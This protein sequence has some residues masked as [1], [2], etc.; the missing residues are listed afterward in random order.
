MTDE[1]QYTVV[2]N[3][4]P[5][6]L[7]AFKELA[8]KATELVRDNE[9]DIKGYQW[10]FNEDETICYT[11]EWHSSSESLLAHLANVGEVLPKILGY[12]DISRFEVFGNPS[13]K[14][15]DA[16]KGLGAEFYGFFDGFTR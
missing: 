12:S 13:S 4:K 11:L 10:Y 9:P 15:M 16:L 2:W 3:I 7:D 6:G 1:L 5:E 8:K 14:A